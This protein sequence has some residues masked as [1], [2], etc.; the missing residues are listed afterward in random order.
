MARHLLAASFLNRPACRGNAQRSGDSIYLVCFFGQFFCSIFLVEP[1]EGE[2][3]ATLKMD[4]HDPAWHADT[5][6]CEQV[7]GALDKYGRRRGQRFH[8]QQGLR[9][10]PTRMP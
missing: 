8:Q 10:G 7:P 9:R 1:E 3:Y 6:A 5:R 2:V 4:R